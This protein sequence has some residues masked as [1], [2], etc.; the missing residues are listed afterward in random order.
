MSYC[1]QI[2]YLIHR[3]YSRPY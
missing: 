2:Y 3:F 1:I